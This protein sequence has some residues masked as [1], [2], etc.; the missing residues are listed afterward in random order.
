MTEVV[1]IFFFKECRIP[2]KAD[3]CC[4]N[5]TYLFL[6]FFIILFCFDGLFRIDTVGNIL[7]CEITGAWRLGNL[8]HV[9]ET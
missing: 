4:Y 2:D 5:V 6:G 7:L 3:K 1:E 8:L 9:F